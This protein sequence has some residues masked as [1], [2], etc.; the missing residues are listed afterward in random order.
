MV[1][2]YSAQAVPFRHLLDSPSGC[3]SISP[4]RRRRSSRPKWTSN[5]EAGM[6]NFCTAATNTSC[7][8]NTLFVTL[9]RLEFLVYAKHWRVCCFPNCCSRHVKNYFASTSLS[10]V[11]A[12][13]DQVRPDSRAD[14]SSSSIA[15]KNTNSV[16]LVGTNV[17]AVATSTASMPAG[18]LQAYIP[19]SESNNTNATIE[20]RISNGHSNDQPRAKLG[21][22]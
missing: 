20:N 10:A 13:I 6:S 9:G 1:A 11:T 19:S 7:I 5:T 21:L 17:E 4:N 3:S 22:C 15:I 8:L 16:Y 12:M 2:P 18:V 14:N